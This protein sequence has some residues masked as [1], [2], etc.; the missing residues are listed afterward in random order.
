MK[1]GLVVFLAL[2]ILLFV[3]CRAG[4]TAP[5]RKVLDKEMDYI[6]KKGD[7]LWDISERFYADPFLWP[8]LWQQNQYITNPHWIYPGDRIRLYP[9]KVLIEVEKPIRPALVPRVKEGVPPFPPPP[10]KIKLFTF[11]EA[12]SAGFITE[13]M[14]G[15]GSI[16]GAKEEKRMLSEADRVHLTFQKGL[17]VHKGDKFAIFRVGDPIVHPITHK[18]LGKRVMILGIVEVTEPEG[19]TKMGLIKLS[20]DPILRGDELFPY[21]PPQEELAINRLEQSLSG[22]IV[23]SKRKKRAFGEGDVVYIDRGER[24]A[25]RPGH[26]FQVF[27]RGKWVIDPISKRKLQLPKDLIGQLVIVRTQEKTCTALI[28]KSRIPI[29]VGDEIV[30]MTD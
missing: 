26:I 7:T 20:V 13:E 5:A 23:A 30:A 15:I 18:V 14:E 4:E 16:V 3:F 11:P 8:R 6:V 1:K 19:D 17:P 24:D 27:R 9:Y 25:V 22:W 28:T 21:V 10:T 12:F 29:H 2:V